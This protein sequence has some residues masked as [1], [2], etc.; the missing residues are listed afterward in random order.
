MSEDQP[1]NEK[2][3]LSTEGYHFEYRPDNNDRNIKRATLYE[4]KTARRVDDVRVSEGYGLPH[5]NHFNVINYFESQLF[6]KKI[7]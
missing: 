4:S 2:F 1:Y 3:H 6:L 5:K 7:K